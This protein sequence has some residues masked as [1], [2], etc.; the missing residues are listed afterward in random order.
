MRFFG[1]VLAL[2]ASS[3]LAAAVLAY[4]VWLLIGLMDDQ[5]IHRI[6][7][8]LAMLSAILGMVWIVRR[9]KMTDRV[10][11]GF[12]VPRRQF[13]KQVG[14]GIV[15]GGLIITPLLVTLQVFDVR[16]ADPRIDVTLG[17]IVKVLFKGLATGLVVAL[18]EEIF[19]R[20]Y[21]FSAI[22]R[23]SGRVLAVV[24]PSL[25][26][27]SV[28]FLDGRLRVPASEI[29]WSSGFTVLSRMF[30]A[31]GNPMQIVDAFLSLFAVGVL[32]S[33][34]RLR[35]GAIALCVG[36]HAAWVCALYYCE[37]TTQIDNSAEH[38]WMAS[39]YDGVIGWAT[40]IWM[41]LLAVAWLWWQRTRAQ[42]TAR[43]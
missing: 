3:L 38:G 7:H 8:R 31:Y 28:H 34:A 29:D 5:P 32:L 1:S 40:V 2:F 39:S 35:T 21:L 41:T 20:G 26:Y 30:L 36:M 10:S 13:W 37:V 17:L 6:L 43:G 24:L 22:E 33:L 14:I 16:Y 19:F 18:I 27:A 9:W 25:L 23:E 12:G 4:P 42:S 11:A 15:I